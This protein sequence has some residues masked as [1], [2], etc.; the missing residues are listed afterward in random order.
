MYGMYRGVVTSV[1]DP[2][3][4]G[5]VQVQIPDLFGMNSTTWAAPC[6][7]IGSS[8]IPP[9]GTPIWVAFEKGQ[10]DHPIW[11]G[12]TRIGSS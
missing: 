2:K 11:M 10:I 6:V 5:R 12:Q 8:T 3:N 4:L 7:D 9:V 1:N